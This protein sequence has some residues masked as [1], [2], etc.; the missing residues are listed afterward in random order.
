MVVLFVWMML[1]V[2]E[3]ALTRTLESIALDIPGK[4]FWARLEYLGIV[5]LPVLWLLFVLEYTQRADRLRGWNRWLL[6]LIPALTVLAAFTNDWHS[7]LWTSF[8]PVSAQ[9]GAS[10]I[11]G[12]GWWYWV[13]VT[14]S[15]LLILVGALVLTWATIRSSP[16][17]RRQ[18]VAMLLAMAIPWMTN[19]GYLLGFR[20]APGL[21]PT[22]LAF[23]LSGVIYIWIF[24]RWQLFN[25]VPVARDALL[26]SMS[27]GVLVLDLQNRVVDANRA[28]R[29]LIGSNAATPIGRPVQEVF[30]AWPEI[31]ARFQ[32]VEHAEAEVWISRDPDQVLD[33]RIAALRDPGGILT[34]RLVV[35]RDISALKR[36][37]AT[38]RESEARLRSL[39][40]GAPDALVISDRTGRIVIVNR[41]AEALFGYARDEM[42]GKPVEFLLPGHVMAQPGL[43]LD[44]INAQAGGQEVL[45]AAKLQDGSEVPVSVNL[46]LVNSTQRVGTNLVR[47]FGPATRR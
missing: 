45:L 19:L 32:D 28:A 36:V 38:L 41:Q 29:R 35:W 11:Y 4:V 3:W 15:Y 31:A 9:P 33:L 37:E 12:R 34:G 24:Y 23:T 20:L 47:D 17:Y 1:A 46:S 7:W 27:D 26:E 43:S 2:A 25:I 39:L 13:A 10:L 6:W 21:D 30:A 18:S 40:E 16:F 5:S 14:Y 8:T 42:I 22:P 44:E